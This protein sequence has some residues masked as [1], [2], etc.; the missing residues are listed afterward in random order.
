MIPSFTLTHR[1]ERSQRY[2]QITKPAK[3]STFNIAPPNA[4]RSSRGRVN[5]NFKITGNRDTYRS[6]TKREKEVVMSETPSFSH[7]RTFA[8]ARPEARQNYMYFCLNVGIRRRRV[9]STDGLGRDSYNDFTKPSS[10][11]DFYYNY[12]RINPAIYKVHPNS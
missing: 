5:D 1:F 10:F 2:S 8:Y 6:A 4:E 11:V 3:W 7:H 12:I 9:W